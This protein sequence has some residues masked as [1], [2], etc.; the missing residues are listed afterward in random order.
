M[1]CP[2]QRSNPHKIIDKHKYNTNCLQLKIDARSIPISSSI[3]ITLVHLQ[4]VCISMLDKDIFTSLMHPT[5][6]ICIDESNVINITI[7]LM[8]YSLLQITL[9]HM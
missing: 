9:I 1:S 6:N 5:Q 7:E 8:K 3:N 2:R 4:D